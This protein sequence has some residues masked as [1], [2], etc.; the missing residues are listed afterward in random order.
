MIQGEFHPL[1]SD[2]GTF[3]KG[4]PG[5]PASCPALD[6]KHRRIVSQSVVHSQ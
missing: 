4:S 6:N 2:V 3:S 1:N 5:Q